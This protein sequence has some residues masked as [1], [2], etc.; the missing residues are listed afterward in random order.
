MTLIPTIL[1]T[2]T[3]MHGQLETPPPTPRTRPLRSDTWPART[4][5]PLASPSSVSTLSGTICRRSPAF[6]RSTTFS[7]KPRSTWV[8]NA[9]NRSVTFPLC[10]RKL[11]TRWWRPACLDPGNIFIQAVLCATHAR[12]GNAPNIRVAVSQSGTIY[13]YI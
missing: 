6:S 12:L 5:P 10:G 9:Y 8:R 4:K 7:P 1:A 13:I 2:S 3:R 11:E